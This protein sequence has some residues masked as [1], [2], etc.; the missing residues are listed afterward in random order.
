MLFKVVIG[1]EG[2]IPAAPL[3]RLG[4]RSSLRLQ[5]ASGLRW[6]WY[7]FLLHAALHFGPFSIL[8]NLLEKVYIIKILQERE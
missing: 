8:R 6:V 5:A 2:R 1:I 7:P 4:L 3:F